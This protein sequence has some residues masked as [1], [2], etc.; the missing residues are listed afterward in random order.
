[1]TDDDDD[2]ISDDHDEHEQE[3]NG[4]ASDDFE[5]VTD[6]EYVESENEKQKEKSKP[7]LRLREILFYDDKVSIFKARHG[8]LYGRTLS[9]RRSTTPNS[10]TTIASHTHR[11]KF[12]RA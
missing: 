7:A 10:Y 3:D 11:M 6:E 1:M 2:D 5:L 4:G 8:R 9:S 12:E